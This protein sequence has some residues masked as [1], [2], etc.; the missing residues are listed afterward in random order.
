MAYKPHRT[1]RFDSVTDLLAA[2]ERAQ[3]RTCIHRSDNPDYP[4]C[5]EMAGAAASELIIEDWREAPDGR[6]VCR[7]AVDESTGRQPTDEPLP[8]EEMT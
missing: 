7:V 4:M 1:A 2:V 5:A 6:V 8:I 3:C